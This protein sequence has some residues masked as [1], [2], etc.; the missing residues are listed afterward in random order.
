MILS[1]IHAFT[2][3]MYLH[4]ATMTSKAF[5]SQISIA[6]VIRHPLDRFKSVLATWRYEYKIG[7]MPGFIPEYFR[8]DCSDSKLFLKTFYSKKD[9][10]Y[11][12]KQ[13]AIFIVACK[14]M[15]DICNNIRLAEA[16]D[17]LNIKMEKICANQ[18]NF[19]Q[20][21]KSL[22]PNIKISE[23]YIDFLKKNFIYK[24]NQHSKKMKIPQDSKSFFN[25]LKEW[26]KLIFFYY[27]KEAH[28]K[29]V[30][31]KYGYD[32]SMLNFPY[33]FYLYYYIYKMKKF[34]IR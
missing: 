22:I 15:Y 6:H 13:T 18:E 8:K 7:R 19:I 33:K 25:S 5:L 29:D 23:R 16:A 12:N 17:I 20:I 26:Q 2:I 32:L 34:F 28:L 27:M 30:Y 31:K 9:L 21:L 24:K 4:R 1:N 10:N 11:K 14:Q 3:P